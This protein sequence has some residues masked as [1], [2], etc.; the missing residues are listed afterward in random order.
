MLDP[1]RHVAASRA[2]RKAGTPVVGSYHSHPTGPPVP[3]PADAEQAGEQG[4]YWLILGRGEARLWRSR[5]GGGVL[6]AFEEVAL[7]LA[8]S[9]AL[10]P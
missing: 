1:S 8:P 7:E 6:G 5:S 2:A 4:R 9:C 3:S 10:Q